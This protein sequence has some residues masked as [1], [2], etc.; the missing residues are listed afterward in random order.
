VYAS[1]L[2]PK[3][4]ESLQGNFC[5]KN[6]KKKKGM[7]NN[8]FLIQNVFRK[9]LQEFQNASRGLLRNQKITR[10]ILQMFD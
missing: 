5:N 10:K 8:L 3:Y 1:I 4:L 2:I 6:E 9:V 7:K